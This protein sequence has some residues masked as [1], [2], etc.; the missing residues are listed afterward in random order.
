MQGRDQKFISVI[1]VCFDLYLGQR[2][3]NVLVNVGY[4]LLQLTKLVS[5]FYL[6]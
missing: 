5:A 4:T 1:V 6:H 3:R 2:E